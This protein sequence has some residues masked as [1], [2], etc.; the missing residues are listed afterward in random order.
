[1]V[2]RTV[3]IKLITIL[4]FLPITAFAQ[5]RR[6]V[7]PS[8]SIEKYM[9]KFEKARDRFGTITSPAEQARWGFIESTYRDIVSYWAHNQADSLYKATKPK[10]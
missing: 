1:M 9:P 2:S 8:D 3:M 7:H 4:F 10:K 5:T 6:D